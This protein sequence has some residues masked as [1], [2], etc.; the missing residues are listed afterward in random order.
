MTLK[1]VHKTTWGYL[2]TL[3]QFLYQ[4]ALQTTTIIIKKRK[5]NHLTC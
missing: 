3:L 1:N 2:A 5:I 4:I